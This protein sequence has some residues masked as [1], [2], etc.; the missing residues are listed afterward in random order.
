MHI[1]HMFP[2][3]SETII[4]IQAHLCKDIVSGNP[5]IQN[6]SRQGKVA[7]MMR[8]IGISLEMF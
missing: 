6:L 1:L 8:N 3:I 4:I 5:S 7:H 2:W